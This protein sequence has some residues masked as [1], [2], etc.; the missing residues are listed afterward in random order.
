LAGRQ[1]IEDA[2]AAWRDA[3][4]RRAEADGHHTPEMDRELEETRAVYHKVAA[5]HM[6]ERLDALRAAEARRATATPSTD[7]YHDA[8]RE[9]RA[10]A[11]E[12]WDDATHL[13]EDTAG[14]PQR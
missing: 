5:D 6:A 12:I 2:L 13:D 1:E 14:A 7:P 8:A 10:I 11:S 4:R 3:E 9:E